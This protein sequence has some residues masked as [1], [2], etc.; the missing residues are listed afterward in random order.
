MI[1]PE[2]SDQTNAKK[3]VESTASHNLVSEAYSS[4]T[5]RTDGSIANADK[6]TAISKDGQLLFGSFDHLYGA[7]TATGTV[8]KPGEGSSGTGGGSMIKESSM[9]LNKNVQT[10]E[11]PIVA[12]NKVDKN[13][14]PSGVDQS[15]VGDCFFEAALASLASSPKGQE[16]IKDMIKTNKDGSFTVTFP[17]DK[18]N[19]VTVTQKDLA[20][21]T[22]NSQVA[23]SGNWAKIIETGFLKY[24]HAEQYGHGLNALQSEGIPNLG[25]IAY[26]DK[27]LH[28]LTGQDV[29]T[30]AIGFTNIDNREIT[31][32]NTSQENIKNAI[33]NSLKSGEPI[34]ATTTAGFEKYLGANSSGPLESSHVFSVTGYDAKTGMV[35]VRNPWGS[36]EGTALAKVGITKD[37]IK[38]LPDGQL[39]MSLNTFTSHFNS[40]NFAGQNPYLNDAENIGKDALHQLGDGGKFG[41]DLFTGNFGKLGGDLW[42]FAKGDWQTTSDILYGITDSGERAVKTVL[43]DAW[44]T[45]SSLVKGAVHDGEEVVHDLNPLNW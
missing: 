2:V 15:T 30:D 21:N 39:E 34:T 42:N 36:N 7:K 33:E 38:T 31:L 20:A 35:T 10:A 22:S 44:D 1:N 13:I 32:G 4:S 14:N 3:P 12:P 18:A 43:S 6:E 5:P 17:G 28:L 29:S 26:S 19:P 9:A 25:N 23:D 16:K 8:G 41:K 37:G 11:A 27:A 40:I 24:D 45:G